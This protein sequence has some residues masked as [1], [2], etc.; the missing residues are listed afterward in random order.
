MKIPYAEKYNTKKTTQKY[1]TKN[2]TQKF[3]TQNNNI[4]IPHT[5]KKHKNSTCKIYN[6]KILHAENLTPKSKTRKY[7]SA[8]Q[9]FLFIFTTRIQH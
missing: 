3:H 2:I 5:K 8:M 1:S 7:N 4:N 6:T 9:R